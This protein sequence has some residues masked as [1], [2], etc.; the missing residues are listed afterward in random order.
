VKLFFH[1]AEHRVELY[2]AFGLLVLLLWFVFNLWV[3]RDYFFPWWFPPIYTET[4]LRQ[5]ELELKKQEIIRRAR[6][7]DAFEL[8]AS[9][10]VG[11]LAVGLSERH[12]R[13]SQQPTRECFAEDDDNGLCVPE[14]KKPPKRM[15]RAQSSRST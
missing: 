14:K 9:I 1:L 8:T 12:V 10:C 11:Q 3:L 7:S 15:V 4:G 5:A 2:Q 6:M 13:Y